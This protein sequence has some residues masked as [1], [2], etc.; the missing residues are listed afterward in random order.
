V[1]EFIDNH[2]RIYVVEMNRDGQLHQ[3]LRLD[4]WDKCV[5][6]I[7]LAYLDGLPLTARW[8]EDAIQ[9]KEMN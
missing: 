3:L 7:S 8:I 6:M 9:A 1:E 4:Y 5:K 2:D